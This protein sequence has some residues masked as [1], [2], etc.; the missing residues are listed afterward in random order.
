[1]YIKHVTF[2]STRLLRA[3]T[4]PPKTYVMPLDISIHKALAS[5]DSGRHRKGNQFPDFNPQGSRE[6]RRVESWFCKGKVNFNPQGSREPRLGDYYRDCQQA[7][8]SIHKALASLDLSSTTRLLGH[9]LISIHKALASLDL[10]WVMVE[11]KLRISIHKALASLDLGSRISGGSCI[12]FNPQGSREPR[13]LFRHQT[14]KNNLIS[15]HKALASLDQQEWSTRFAPGNFNPQG[16]REPRRRSCTYTSDVCRISIHKAL[17]SLD[18]R[19]PLHGVSSSYFNPQGSRE[20]RRMVLCH[21]TGGIIF[22]STRLSR[23]ST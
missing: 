9:P 5:L 8:I 16:S 20:P 3:S 23:A 4:I 17:A 19:R 7:R 11:L 6:P 18:E 22:Q 1:M 2:Q 12:Y 21:I 14:A 13:L 10:I 15:I